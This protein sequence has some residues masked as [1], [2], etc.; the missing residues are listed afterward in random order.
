MPALLTPP[1][2]AIQQQRAT[3]IRVCAEILAGAMALRGTQSR[4]L[5][6][7][8]MAGLCQAILAMASDQEREMMELAEE[9]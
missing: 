2:I 5:D 1:P 3:G 4:P 6:D 7:Q 9:A 8:Q